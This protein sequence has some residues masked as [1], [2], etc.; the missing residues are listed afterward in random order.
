MADASLT[1]APSTH[2]G[3]STLAVH[4]S[5]D[6]AGL[7]RIGDRVLVTGSGRLHGGAPGLMASGAHLPLTLGM[8][9]GTASARQRAGPAVCG[10]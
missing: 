7:A 10:C 8:L 6:L 4:L 9:V 5:D 3:A 1:Q 2:L